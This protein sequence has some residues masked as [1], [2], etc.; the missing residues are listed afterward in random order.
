ML[1]TLIP[2]TIVTGNNL[3]KNQEIKV[4][5]ISVADCLVQPWPML[6]VVCLI[7]GELR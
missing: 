1:L 7:M 6:V 3:K 2:A 4:Q 5:V